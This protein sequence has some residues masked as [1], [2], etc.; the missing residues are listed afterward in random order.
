MSK[1]CT[2]FCLDEAIC[3]K[4]VGM[5][6]QMTMRCL[7]FHLAAIFT[8]AWPTTDVV[9]EEGVEEAALTPTDRDHWAYRPLVK[10]TV[11]QVAVS[12]WLVTPVDSF[13]LKRLDALGLS[14]GRMADRAT[15]LRRL[16]FDLSG[17]PP[18]PEE[19]SEFESDQ[20]PDAYER[21]VDRWL[22]SPAY[23]ER[24]AQHWLDLARFAETDG[25]EHDFVRPD[26]WKYRDWVIQAFNTDLPYGDFVRQQLAG[27]EIGDGSAAIATMFCLAGPDMPDINDQ[28]QRRHFRLNELTA[29]VGAVFLGMQIG[30]A[31]CHDH[32]S[33]PISQADFY[34]L[35]AVFEPSIPSFQRDV[36]CH[37][38][39][40]Q[41]D[42]APARLWIRGDH[43]R[44]GPIVELAI[45]RIAVKVGEGTVLSV[46]RTGPGLRTAAADALVNGSTPLTQRV[47][48]NRCW[49]QHF[50]RG[51][52]HQ[53]S[54][55]G[56][57]NA[58]P[59]HPELLEWLAVDL[60]E[61][62]WSLK[63]LHRRMV[64]SATY[65]QSSRRSGDDQ[66]WDRRLKVDP[67]N[68]WLSRSPRRRLD[69]ESLRDALLAVAGVLNQTQGGPGVRPPLPEELVRT[70]LKDQ[71]IA[72]PNIG[73]HTRRSIYLFAR[74]NLRYPL[75][76][77][78][79]RPDA[80]ASCAVRVR[81][82]TAPQALV[83]LNGDVSLLAA[84]SLAGRVYSASPESEQ[85]IRTLFRLTLTRDPS[86]EEWRRLADFVARQSDVL[87]SV[88]RPPAEL[89]QPV[90]DDLR[91]DPYEGAAWVDACLALLNSNEFLYCD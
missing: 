72:S 67:E 76:E 70:L 12:S 71:W 32:K 79:D 24:W 50:G 46:T 39:S 57:A 49:Q 25:F 52:S 10:P 23:G 82:T 83:L 66:D 84:R 85:R 60:T 8:L 7:A 48:A 42:T 43:R 37:I 4:C 87:R 77:S 63:H 33:D 5:V 47:I 44:P 61:H 20:S 80:N 36:S 6:G 75:L 45:P 38:L 9:A 35:R 1:S 65:R 13:I 62:D 22:A 2:E 54:D 58:E 11:P 78:F 81:S 90:P 41:P 55:F 91:I 88:S 14:P 69:G 51:I 30:C 16:T 68:H 26:A 40:N 31:E 73:D 86:G 17:L 56:I 15:L 29:T 74:R 59:T 3:R 18:A 64:V 89:L 19:L 53:P 27:D 21:A 34:R 28:E